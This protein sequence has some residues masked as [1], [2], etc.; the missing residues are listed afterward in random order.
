MLDCDLGPYIVVIWE[1]LTELLGLLHA[2]VGEEGIVDAVAELGDVLH[3]L[4]RQLHRLR[5]G[6][7]VPFLLWLR[8]D[9]GGQRTW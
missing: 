2:F 6:V 5:S 4:A 8:S 7:S 1:L 9:G 3:S